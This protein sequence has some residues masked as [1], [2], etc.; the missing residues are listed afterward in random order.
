[1]PEAFSV[2]HAFCDTLA[3]AH[4]V[5]VCIC[6][7]DAAADLYISE[8]VAD[9]DPAALGLEPDPGREHAARRR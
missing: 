8:A 2:A 1:M 4:A 5:S 6:V 7:A 3:D 9:A